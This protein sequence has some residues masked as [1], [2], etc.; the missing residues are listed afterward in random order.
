MREAFK[1]ALNRK[2]L[3]D[4]TIYTSPLSIIKISKCKIGL[5]TYFI[6]KMIEFIKT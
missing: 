5:C 3:E 2:E 1:Y 4:C 6:L